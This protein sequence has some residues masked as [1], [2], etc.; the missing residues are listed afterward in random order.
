MVTARRAQLRG[1]F[2]APEAGYRT[3]AHPRRTLPPGHSASRAGQ[4]D[5]VFF[6]LGGHGQ[7]ELEWIELRENGV[8]VQ[9]IT[10]PGSTDPRQRSNDYLFGLPSYHA[11]SHYT[12]HAS[13]RGIGGADTFGDIYVISQ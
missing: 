4:Y 6:Q 13:V 3:S 10:R 11:G 1:F 5:V 9:R 8:P 7:M 12:I 2:R